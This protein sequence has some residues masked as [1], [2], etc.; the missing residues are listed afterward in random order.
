MGKTTIK[1]TD[2]QETENPLFIEGLAGVG[3]IGRNTVSY[4]AESMEAKKIGEITSSHFPPYAIVSDDKT[5]Q[6][7]KTKYMN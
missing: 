4:V 5:V 2:E 3:H 6:T 7:I 1:M